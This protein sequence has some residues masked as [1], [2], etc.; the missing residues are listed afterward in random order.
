[1]ALTDIAIRNAK[2]GEKAIKLSDSG[3]LHLLVAPNGNKFWRL[4]YRFDGKQKQLA[5]GAYPLISLVEARSKR[6]D[7]KK[8]L[9]EGIDPSAAKRTDR[10]Q[11][12]L[13]AASTFGVLAKEWFANQDGRWVKSYADRIWSRIEDDLIPHLGGRP[14]EEIEALEML[15]VLRKIEARGA[16]ESA[17]RI[18]G[19]ASHILQYAL[20]TGRVTRDVTSDIE[21]A[22]KPINKSSV[23]RRAWLKADQLPEFLR[24]LN[25]YDGEEETQLALRTT[26]YTFVRTN[27]IRFAVKG[28]FEGLDGKEPIWRIPEERMKMRLPHIVPLAP[29]VVPMI[30]RLIEM[31]P[32]S[33]LLFP[34]MDGNRTGNKA[35]SENTMIYAMYRMGYKTRATVHGF[36]STASTILN[37][38]QFNSDHIEKQL[39]HVEENEVRAAYNAAE[40]LPARRKMM[41]WWA[42]YLDARERDGQVIRHLRVA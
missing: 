39:A 38:K 26:L 12:R 25:E 19:Y 30:Q 17:K 34:S 42:D 24:K 1:M 40:W 36:R 11:Q 37:E 41:N 32:R 35:M 20:I 27:E 29:Q 9:N 8:L 28:E 21:K 16:I 4:A 7:A 18:K 13:D 31:N 15:E 3:G 5:I 6:D 14:A 10:V 2:P 23:K 22:L 33:D